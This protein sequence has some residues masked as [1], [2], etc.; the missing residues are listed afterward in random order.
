MTPVPMVKAHKD[1]CDDSSCSQYLCKEYR[2]MGIEDCT[3]TNGIGDVPPESNF[4]AMCAMTTGTRKQKLLEVFESL[5]VL[6]CELT[7]TQKVMVAAAMEV[8]L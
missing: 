6:K 1:P 2:E 3:Q 7:R 5:R 8:R 4:E